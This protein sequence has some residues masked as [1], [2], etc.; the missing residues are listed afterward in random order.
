MIYVRP[1]RDATPLHI[2]EG[3]KRRLREVARRV[4]VTF[5]NERGGKPQPNWRALIVA[6]AEGRLVVST[7]PATPCPAVPEERETGVFQP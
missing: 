6:I 1:R 2:S 4:G 3:D 5:E 7:P